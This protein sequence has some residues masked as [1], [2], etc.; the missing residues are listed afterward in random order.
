MRK[1]LHIN[2]FHLYAKAKAITCRQSEIRLWG[3]LKIYFKVFDLL[4]LRAALECIS[5]FLQN[6][7]CTFNSTFNFYWKGSKDLL[8]PASIYTLLHFKEYASVFCH[9]NLILSLYIRPYF[10]YRNLK[11]STNNKIN[12]H[13]HSENNNNA[14]FGP[15]RHVTKNMDISYA[16]VSYSP[17]VLSR[18]I[19]STQQCKYSAKIQQLEPVL[20]SQCTLRRIIF[21][22]LFNF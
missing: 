12:Q 4:T 19:T 1:C 22:R 14:N 10:F 2:V 21:K 18:E 20:C 11:C 16:S 13:A 5:Y 6:W 15:S 17:P 9:I 8:E 7:E 3:S